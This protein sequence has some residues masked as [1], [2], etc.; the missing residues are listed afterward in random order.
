[1][2]QWNNDKESLNAV[3]ERLMTE[4]AQWRIKEEETRILLRTRAPGAAELKLK[5]AIRTIVDERD[6]QYKQIDVY[7]ETMKK[8]LRLLSQG[9]AGEAQKVLNIFLFTTIK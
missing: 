5:D 7:K 8:V 3:I 1:M 6:D 9:N 4:N 2:G